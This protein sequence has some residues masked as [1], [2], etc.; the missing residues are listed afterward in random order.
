M[1]S[2]IP[3]D[4][5][6][7]RVLLLSIWCACFLGGGAKGPIDPNLLSSCVCVCVWGGLAWYSCGFS[8]RRRRVSREKIP[9]RAGSPLRPGRRVGDDHQAKS[10]GQRG[11][12]GHSSLLSSGV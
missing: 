11:M 3:L 4:Q 6:I 5:M 12:G 1:C 9:R 2:Q 7:K 10:Q 8:R